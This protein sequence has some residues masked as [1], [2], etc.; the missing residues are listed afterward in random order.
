MNST[1][2][3]ISPIG[4]IR[5]GE[6][7]MDDPAVAEYTQEIREHRTALNNCGTLSDEDHEYRLNRIATAT[8]ILANFHNCDVNDT[9]DHRCSRGD[10]YL[11]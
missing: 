4:R 2:I 3:V 5:E 8:H 7:L 6:S 11:I 10:F 9:W 1:Q